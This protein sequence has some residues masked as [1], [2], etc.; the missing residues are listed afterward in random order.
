LRFTIADTGP[1]IPQAVLPTLFA[2]DKLITGTE[3][4]GEGSGIGLAIVRILVD[5]WVRRLQ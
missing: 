5:H 4:R 1:G 3:R 2:P